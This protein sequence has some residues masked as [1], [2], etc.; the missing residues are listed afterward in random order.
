MRTKLVV[1]NW[2]MNMTNA[3]STA[4]VETFLKHVSAR[5]NVDVV[6]CPPFINVP[7]AVDAARSPDYWFPRRCPRAMAWV[8]PSTTDADRE[9][10]LGPGGGD[11]VHA[12]E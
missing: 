5:S 8:T 7:P 12:I 1:G 11:R 4:A 9:R 3:E 6:I 2:K 10:I